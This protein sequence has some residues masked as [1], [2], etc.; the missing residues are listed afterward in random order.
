MRILDRAKMTAIQSSNRLFTL[1]SSSGFESLP[2]NTQSRV[3]LSDENG[4]WCVVDGTVTG[5]NFAVNSVEN[6][7]SGLD[8]PTF[9]GTIEV[10]S[11]LGGKAI[12]RDLQGVGG[13]VYA[14]QS[15]AV[16]TAPNRDE[17]I[18]IDDPRVT[19]Y[20][21]N[22]DPAD[23]RG[24]NYDDN[25]I[26]L[27]R[28]PI[29]FNKV[30]GYGANN[31]GSHGHFGK[32]LVN[33]GHRAIRVLPCAESGSAFGTNNSILG[34]AS[35]GNLWRANDQLAIRTR[36][37]IISF[38]NEDENNYIVAFVWKHG[39]TD[40]YTGNAMDA[41]TYANHF[42]TFW[43][44]LVSEVQLGTTR[45]YNMIDEGV[46]LIVTGMP[47]QYVSG[48]N[49]AG[50]VQTALIDTPNRHDWCAFVDV[51]AYTGPDPV[52]FNETTQRIMGRTLLPAAFK[53]A[54][55][56]AP[57]VAAPTTLT[58]TVNHAETP[59]SL[60]ASGTSVGGG[61]VISGSI[62]HTETADALTAS[63]SAASGAATPNT[64]AL[65]PYV[66]LKRGEGVTES[67]G[68]V[69]AWA[70]A[71]GNG[72]SG[73]QGTANEQP[74]WNGTDIVFDSTPYQSPNVTDGLSFSNPVLN[75]P[76][77]FTLIIDY[78]YDASA[79][80]YVLFGANGILCNPNASG[81]TVRTRATTHG[82]NDIT[83]PA[84]FT[85]SSRHQF[86]LV[87]DVTG[88]TITAYLDG[89]QIDQITSPNW[90][91]SPTGATSA[92]GRNGASTTFGS[93]ATIYN[94]TVFNDKALSLAQINQVVA[95]YS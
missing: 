91:D 47:Q 29:Y 54:K 82:D 56:N 38:L 79:N 8:V 51:S 11:S 88:N 94:F 27:H 39:E 87:V 76:D 37:M 34:D 50:T 30:S 85:D 61:T 44:W 72:N 16:G 52:H 63:G 62:S 25:E 22:Y 48:A 60:T 80:N 70:D 93:D 4:N 7:S 5:S 65:G 92:L 3:C 9:S 2:N 33:N 42:D 31:V 40:S 58:G 10:I 35:I 26:L 64:D 55:A 90:T 49:Y 66:Q 73:T 95:E 71:S 45:S 46:P 59:D 81:G 28:E 13:L 18:D 17:L 20:K 23:P 43:A 57:T 12:E 15:N 36:D 84:S 69:S 83:L 21:F 68:L 86:A 67:G 89:T 74:A 41:A 78:Q 77:K 32:W 6:G 1:I 53:A 75:I 19:Q 14:G 24:S